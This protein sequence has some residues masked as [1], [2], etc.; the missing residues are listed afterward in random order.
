MRGIEFPEQWFIRI[1]NHMCTRCIMATCSKIGCAC[2]NLYTE[3]P[4]G[5]RSG[6]CEDCGHPKTNHSSEVQGK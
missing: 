4:L 5:S 2:R 6:N 3:W 1:N